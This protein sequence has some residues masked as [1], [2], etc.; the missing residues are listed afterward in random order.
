M[1]IDA[2]IHEASWQTYPISNLTFLCFFFSFWDF[3]FILSS[4]S[5]PFKIANAI[6]VK[7]Q[8]DKSDKKTEESFE[9]ELCKEKEAGE[10][11]RLVANDGD[12]CRDV[13]QCTTSV[14]LEIHVIFNV[15][16][17]DGFFLNFQGLQAIRCPAGLYFDIEK[18]T[19]DWK[20]AVKNCKLKNKERKVKPLLITDEPLCQDGFLACGDGNCV[21]RGLFCNGEKDCAD[22]SDENSCGEFN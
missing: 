8:D 4:F 12:S 9:Q 20:E 19:C 14:R 13:I 16:C 5:S 7:R 3:Y 6:R 21:E 2:F 18:Q 1:R 10:W 22:G 15:I 11:F 17:D